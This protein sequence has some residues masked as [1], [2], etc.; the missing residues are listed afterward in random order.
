MGKFNTKLVGSLDV[1]NKILAF[2][3]VILA[4]VRFNDT[5]SGDLLG[6]IFETLSVIGVGILSTGYIAL[7]LNI[8]QVLGEIRDQRKQ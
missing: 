3:F 2:I 4:I 6:S 5:V 1:L 8:N 7:M